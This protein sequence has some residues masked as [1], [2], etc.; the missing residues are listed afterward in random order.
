MKQYSLRCGRVSLLDMVNPCLLPLDHLG[1]CNGKVIIKD[2][3]KN[4]VL[5]KS[6]YFAIA[7]W[8]KNLVPA[9]DTDQDDRVNK[10]L[11]EG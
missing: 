10:L 6:K 2:E 9:S 8:S 7:G 3:V 11:E 1:R 5:P 4:K